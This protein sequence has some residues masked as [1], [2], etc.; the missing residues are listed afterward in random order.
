MSGTRPLNQHH[1]LPISFNMPSSNSTENVLFHVDYEAGRAFSWLS[2][3]LAVVTALFQGLV[4]ALAFMTESSSRWTF[5]FRLALIE[6][7]WWSFVSIFLLVSLV[8]SALAFASGNG[9]EA[10]SVLA[11]ASATFLAM[12]QYLLPAWQHRHYTRTRWYAW[13]G[14]SRTAISKDDAVYCG[15]AASWQILVRQNSKALS[16]LNPTPSD[17]YGWHILPLKG[18]Q[19]DPA[20]ILNVLK[21][22]PASSSSLPLLSDAEKMR[23]QSVGIYHNALPTTNRVSL[24]WGRTLN[25]QPRVSRAVNSMPLGLLRSSPTTVD[26]YDGKGLAK[27]MGILGRNKGLEPLKL[28]FSTP[29]GLTSYMENNSTWTPRPAKVLRSFYKTTLVQQYGGL[30][31]AY[32]NAAVELALLLADVPYWAADAWLLAGLEHQDLETNAL[33]AQRVPMSDEEKR[34]ALQAHYESSYISMIVCL[35]NMDVRMK[36]RRGKFRSVVLRRP[37]LTCTALLLKVRGQREP[38]WW[39]E[40]E[41]QELRWA[42]DEAL[43]GEWKNIAARLCGLNEWPAGW[44]KTPLSW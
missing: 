26:G 23:M 39:K 22:N 17:R 5:R 36:G 34:D 41:V 32:V 16:L 28:V 10:I 42:Q 15:N 33:L 43:N 44:D 35:N 31:D 3:G 12:V 14:D 4:T 27:A 24:R 6:H 8:M 21:A 19:Y 40:K 38:A 18:I 37:D 1:Y 11:L 7:I 20:D 9:G 29:D 2:I 25:F 30:K 13:T